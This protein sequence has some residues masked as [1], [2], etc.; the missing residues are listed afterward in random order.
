MQIFASVGLFQGL[1][2]NARGT[3]DPKK[4]ATSLPEITPKFGRK[5]NQDGQKLAK[6]IGQIDQS[7]G[8]NVQIPKR[9]FKKNLLGA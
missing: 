1:I 4:P 8:Q 9:D 2:S 7:F 5:F 3:F 6:K